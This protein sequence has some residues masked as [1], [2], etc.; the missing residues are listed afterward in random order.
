M[1]QTPP[2]GG[3]QVF[4]RTASIFVRVSME[5]VGPDNQTIFV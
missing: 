3:C 5:A 4:L 1:R 2:K